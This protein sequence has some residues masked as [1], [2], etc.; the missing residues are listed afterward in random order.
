MAL[1]EILYYNTYMEKE[2]L[3]ETNYIGVCNGVTC[4]SKNS[5]DILLMVTTILGVGVGETTPD[6]RFRVE[7]VPC[8][9]K[10]DSAPKVVVNGEILVLQ[11]AEDLQV[12]LAE[13]LS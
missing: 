3:L 6:G 2:N 1:Y 4:S 12:K 7:S 13:L 11:T 9:G 10:C 8:M 5:E